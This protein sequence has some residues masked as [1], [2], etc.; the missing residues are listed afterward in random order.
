MPAAFA[1]ESDKEPLSGGMGGEALTPYKIRRSLYLHSG[2]TIHTSGKSNP[3][4]EQKTETVRSG[5]RP[6]DTVSEYR[7]RAIHAQ[8]PLLLASVRSSLYESPDIG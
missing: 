6:V 8:L 3:I 7:P 2:G 4:P 1:S 5:L